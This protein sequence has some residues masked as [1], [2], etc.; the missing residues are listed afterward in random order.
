MRTR[1]KAKFQQYRQ[2]HA[3]QWRCAGILLGIGFA[4]YLLIQFTPFH[5]FC[6]FQRITKLA[7]P[8]CGITHFLVRLLHFDIP[9]AVQENVAVAG[10]IL[11]WGPLLFIR[12][13]WHPKWL[14]KNGRFE[15]ILACICVVLL[16]LF[17]ILRNLPGMEFLL[18]SSMR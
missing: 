1:Q 7:C 4:Y 3:K 12:V 16:L 6:L 18:P 2:K 15:R 10:L 14:Q 11:L 8:G 17:G 5:L 9:G 13:I